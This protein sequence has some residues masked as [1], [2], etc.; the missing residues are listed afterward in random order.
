MRILVTHNKVITPNLLVQRL[1]IKLVLE[2]IALINILL[3]IIFPR[4]SKMIK[5]SALKKRKN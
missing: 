2:V 3:K 1:K 4:L 5:S